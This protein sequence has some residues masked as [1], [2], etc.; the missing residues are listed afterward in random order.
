MM[1][2]Q[3]RIMSLIIGVVTLSIILFFIRKRRLDNLYAFSW[4][5][6]SISFFVIAVFP[7]VIE[8]AALVLGVGF[9]PLAIVIMSLLGMGLIMFNLTIIITSHNKKIREFE[10]EISL[11]KIEYTEKL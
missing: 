3:S 4:M 9:T 6:V 7:L 1:S 11:L 5:V 2:Y 8:R 10:K